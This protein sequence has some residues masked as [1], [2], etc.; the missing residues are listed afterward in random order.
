MKVPRIHEA[1]PNEPPRPAAFLIPFQ[2]LARAA[3]KRRVCNLIYGTWVFNMSKSSGASNALMPTYARQDLVFERG[4]GVWLVTPTGERFLD[5]TSGIAVNALGHAHPK[6]I[7]ALETQAEKLW[8]TSNLF[9]V[10]GQEKLADRLCAETFADRVFFANSGAEACEGAI[11]TARRYHFSK[12]NPERNRIIT[13]EGAFHGRTLAT[14]A[15]GAVPKHMEGFA[16]L[17][18]GFDQ[19]PF[20]DFGALADA[21]G[22]ETAAI[23]IEPI[24]GEGGVREL[25]KGLLRKIRKLCDDNEI[26]L[27]VDE[28][29]TGIG[30]TGRLFA[31]EWEDITPD[32]MAIAKGI[33]GGFPLGA[34]LATENAASGMTPGTHGSTF[35][36]NSLA[37]AVGN[38]VL[39]IVLPAEFLESV[40]QKG[41]R[42]RQ[43]LA[44]L[45]DEFPD[46]VEDVRGQGLLTGL[47]VKPSNQDVV[48]AAADEKL[49]IV[50]AGDNVVRLIPPLTISEEEL[51]EA[52]DRL[53]RAFTNLRSTD[54]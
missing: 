23:M 34:F 25:P 24:Q 3:T 5:L 7:E 6:L 27:I 35:G 48:K 36:G 49:L 11:K 53:Q 41:L 17:T 44:E 32:I 22:P 54:T 20:A 28:V 40:R 30:R 42:L 39:D 45:Q 51:G 43:Q 46:I 26:L 2:M 8:H 29:Q 50:G 31:H 9:R 37:M 10:A 4:E 1:T 15:A 16:P 19:V 33:G 12:G 13:F 14:I 47:K 38:A 52:R 18:P 21:I